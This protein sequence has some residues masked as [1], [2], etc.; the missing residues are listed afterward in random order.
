MVINHC[1]YQLPTTPSPCLCRASGIVVEQRLID[2]FINGTAMCVAHGK[3]LPNWFRNLETIDFIA[4][5]AD[6]LEVNHANSHD[7]SIASIA[8]AY[9]DL[10][11]VRRGSPSM[12]GGTWIHPD[13][14][15][16]LAQW[17]NPRFSLYAANIFKCSR[18]SASNLRQ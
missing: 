11:T 13:L 2:G 1:Y 12:G 7:S 4:A 17:C 16:P 14:A 6:D 18:A 9:P 8:A 15:V 5:L 3:F 10:I